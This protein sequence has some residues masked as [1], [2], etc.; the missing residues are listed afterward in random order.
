MYLKALVVAVALFPMAVNAQSAP[1]PEAKPKATDLGVAAQ[2][3]TA[4]VDAAKS[5]AA[6]AV[7]AVE[8]A[9]VVAADEAKS[10]AA[11]A[12]DAAVAA[13]RTMAESV[14]MPRIV[15]EVD[16]YRIM[17]I[18]AGTAGGLVAANVLTG[19]LITPIL[20][21][22]PMITGSYAMAAT[23]TAA[24]AAGALV[25]AYIGNWVYEYCSAG[26]GQKTHEGAGLARQ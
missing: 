22:G 25:G 18:A 8:S 6:A 20:A 21:G 19:G 9:A 10:V 11:D 2:A 16:G 1:S 14:P 4:E 23:Q 15:A 24:M 7:Q 3:E 12:A 13:A 26:T 17:A 5:K